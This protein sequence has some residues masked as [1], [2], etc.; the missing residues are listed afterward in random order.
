MKRNLSLLLALA[1]ILSLISAC[2]APNTTE[3]PAAETVPAESTP[4]QSAPGENLPIE[5]PTEEENNGEKTSLEQLRESDNPF[6]L[7]E[8]DLA[9]LESDEPWSFVLV[10]NSRDEW[11]TIWMEKVREN[12]EALGGTFSFTNADSTV[13]KQMADIESVLADNPDVL[14]IKAQEGSSLT[15][16]VEEARAAGT[17]IIDNEN[18]IPSDLCNLHMTIIDYRTVG[19]MQ[20]KALVNWLEEHPEEVI[21][22]G[23]MEGNNANTPGHLRFEGLEA[24]LA[25][26]DRANLIVRHVHEWNVTKAMQITEDWITAYP[27][28][29]AI[30]SA[31]D[32]TAVGIINALEGAGVK[33]G[34]GVGEFKVVGA[35]GMLPAMEAIQ[36]GKMFGTMFGSIALDA[37]AEATYGKLLAMGKE[38]EDVEIVIGEAAMTWVNADNID[39]QI[40]VKRAES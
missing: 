3:P 36:K 25:E 19:Y 22:V 2:A 24:A 9:L 28:M 23:Y 11:N 21:N 29:N 5:N 1:L 38:M 7:S 34:A 20:G 27:E 37:K 14:L 16:I 18:Q 6:N 33:V 26:S 17:K 13:E 15:G 10:L 8:E 35:D 39:E 32:E 31:N 4:V 12:V 40:E 30:V